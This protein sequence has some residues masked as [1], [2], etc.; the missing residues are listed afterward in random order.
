MDHSHS[1]VHLKN[2]KM[3]LEILQVNFGMVCVTSTASQPR[4][5]LTFVLI[6]S[7]RMAL[8]VTWNTLTSIFI[9]KNHIIEQTTLDFSEL[10]QELCTHLWHQIPTT[11]PAI[12]IF[13]YNP[14][15]VLPG[16]TR[17]AII[18]AGG[19]TF[20]FLETPMDREEVGTKQPTHNGRECLLHRLRSN[21]VLKLVLT[22]H[23]ISA[24]C[25]RII[26]R[27]S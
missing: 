17:P 8:L 14:Y 13:M 25:S 16:P 9:P 11:M 24:W 20:I 22:L 1:I 27:L 15:Q 23:I 19:G 5:T 10:L 6:S 18:L 12:R 21:Y 26:C 4:D 2:M 7:T 3:V